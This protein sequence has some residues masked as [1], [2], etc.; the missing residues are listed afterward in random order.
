MKTKITLHDKKQLAEDI[1][2]L[3]GLKHFV[4]KDR[5]DQSLCDLFNTNKDI[6]GNRGSEKRA[7]LRN[8]VKYWDAYS[9]AGYKKRFLTNSTWKLTQNAIVL[10]KLQIQTKKRRRRGYVYSAFRV[11]LF[12]FPCLTLLFLD[13]F[14]LTSLATERRTIVCAKSSATISFLY[15]LFAT[16][17]FAIKT[18]ANFTFFATTRFTTSSNIT[19]SDPKNVSQT[20]IS[21]GHGRRLQ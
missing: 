1:E 7:Q 3:G 16:T 9:Q 19:T 21:H 10:R 11:T 14:L 17:R 8:L 2:R 12:F 18:C 15:T 6:Y 4:N 5:T 13:C 20:K